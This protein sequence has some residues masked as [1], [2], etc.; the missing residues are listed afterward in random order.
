MNDR[1]LPL[2]VPCRNAN[3]HT[4]SLTVDVHGDNIVL[5]P[6]PGGV[7]VLSADDSPLLRA[8]LETAEA[9]VHGKQRPS[10]APGGDPR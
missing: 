10:Q 2:T 5:V 7:T 3:G 8:V 9:V 4:R 1:T 6:P